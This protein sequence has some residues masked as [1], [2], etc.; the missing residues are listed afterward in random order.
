M[1]KLVTELSPIEVKRLTHPGSGRNAM[2]AVGGVS[3][4]YLQITPTGARSWI[5]RTTIGDK[6]RDLGLGAYPDVGLAQARERARE[7]KDKVWRGID[8]IEERKAA[9]AALTA[10]QKRGLT[11][12]DAFRKYADAKL[13]E[14]GTDADRTRWK[15]SIERFVLPHIGDMLVDDIAVQDMLRVLE[16]IWHE[17]TETASR[18]RSR[19]EAI[20]SWSTV[21]GH[22]TG[23]NPARWRGNLNALL[24][25]PAKITAKGNQPA[26]AMDEAATWFNALRK[27]QG[28][29]ARALEFAA[30]CASR[31]GEVRGATWA[32]IDTAAKI[33]T[34]S[35]ER[36]KAEREHRVALTDQAV[37]IVEAMP[38]LADSPYIFAAPRGGQLSDMTISAVMR[39]MQADEVKAG[40]AGWL[41][42][43]SGRPAVPHGLRSTFR[44]WAAEQTDYPRDMAEIALA[45][46]VGSEVE[47][48]YRRGDM[49]EKRRQM[50]ADWAKFLGAA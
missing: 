32:E 26:V 11:F 40:R 35:A 33:W 36:M 45:H 47:R 44:D 16:P 6:R 30:L 28:I 24:P 1:P 12:G 5:L 37:A 49:I 27:R 14:L 20:L 41:D 22:R 3:G 21:G 39:R 18:V 50:M 7:A 10:S 29:A 13:A 42:P 48:A 19:I 31:S 9:R 43:R 17:K 15:S 38:R 2:L 23:D 8:P 34:I 25:K 46:R 4:L